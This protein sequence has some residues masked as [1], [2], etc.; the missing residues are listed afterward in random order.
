M[1]STF[2]YLE[3]HLAKTEAG[4]FL[5][6]PNP[7]LSDAR[8][9]PHLYRFDTIYHE[10]MLR[11]KGY[12][13]FEPE[14]QFPNLARYISETMFPLVKNSC[15]L[16][17]ANRF[18]FSSTPEGEADRKYDMNR[19]RGQAWLPTREEWEQKRTAEGFQDEQMHT[20]ALK[21]SGL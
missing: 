6:G 3:D 10:L 1:Q 13:I 20:V 8:A 4:P 14:G 21:W 12:R 18:Y 7:T 9:F 5:L 2:Q 11:N 16:Q 17:V 15:D 19:A